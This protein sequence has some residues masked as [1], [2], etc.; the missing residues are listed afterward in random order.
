MQLCNE[1][2]SSSVTAESGAAGVHLNVTI[3][4]AGIFI[5]LALKVTCCLET[6]I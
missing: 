6:E 5:T 1:S 2:C 3:V 4:I